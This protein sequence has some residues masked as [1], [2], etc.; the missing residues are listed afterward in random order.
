MRQ[1]EELRRARS[2]LKAALDRYAALYDFSPAGYLTLDT[3]GTI[4]EANLRA[5]TLLGVNQKELIGQSFG[6]F[7]AQDDQDTLQRHCQEV[8]KTGTPQS[9]EVRLTEKPGASCCV[10]LE[11]IVMYEE[12]GHRAY[13]RTALLDITER[14]RAEQEQARLIEDLTRS[15]QHFQSL[16]HWIPSAVG[17]S[18]VADG[19]FI[20]VNEGFSGLTGYRREEVIGRT[21]LEL[22]MWADPS[23]R[24]IVIQ[25]ILEQGFLHNREGQLRTKSGEIRSLMI[26]VHSIQLEGTP[27]LIY[28]AHDITERKLAEEALKVSERQFASFMDNLPGFAW[29]KDAQGR[30]LYA[31]RLFQESLVKHGD[32]KEKTAF[33]L[34]PRE[35][36]AKYEIDD[37][38]VLTSGAP[39]Q[40][41]E[42]Y[43]QDGEVRHALVS[44]FPIE[45][46]K[47]VSG[48][49]G[50]IAIDITERM[51]VEEALRKSE[52]RY[53]ALYQ[54]SPFMYFTVSADGAILSVN[55][56]GAESL[57][58]LVEELI[59]RPVLSIFHEEDRAAARVSLDRSLAN[60]T[61]LATWEFRK[62]RKGGTI[63]WVRETVRLIEDDCGALV[64]LLACEDITERKRAEEALRESE[65]RFRIMA[66]T[67]PTL[68]W[69]SGLDKL[70]IYFN[71]VWLDYTGRTMEQE[72][73]KGWVDSVHPG[74]FDRCWKTYAEAFDRRE[75]FQMEYRL[76]KAD[77]HYG[78][79]FDK[80]VP[81]YFPSG[82][83]AGYIG[84]CIDITE[85][86]WAE[87]A[88]QASDAFTRA[89]LNSLSAYVC[90]LDKEGIIV[91]TN[92]AW[93][94]FARQDV[95]SAFI[96]GE[97]SDHYLDHCRH[98]ITG[99]TVTDQAVLNGV[100][101]VLAGRELGFSYEYACQLPTEERWFLVRVTPL[102]DAR[103]V[104]ISHTDISR[105]VRMGLALEQHAVLLGEK[106][107]ELESLAGKL[108]EAQE[109]ERKRIAR[110]LHDDFN[111][112]LA[113]LSLELEG[114]ERAPLAP[115]ELM[116]QQLAAIRI[117][118]GKL[119]DDLHDLAYRLHPS[120]L[121]HVGLEVAVRDHVAEFAKR[122]GLPVR[123]IVREVPKTLSSEVATNLFRVLQESL[124]N[125]SKH[126]QATDVTVRLSGSSKGIGLSVR[127]NGKGFDLEDKNASVKGLG[128]VSM[129]ERARGLGGF[130]RIHS[131]PKN[132]TKVC[133]W[134]PHVQEDA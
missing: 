95:E 16:F 126:A 117:Q 123:F 83:F 97:V 75:P 51:Q 64:M 53:R 6:H 132:G 26:S 131:L 70:C 18:T 3:S 96:S 10:H 122:T 23:Q 74:D 124:Q 52:D 71:Q 2:E 68:I 87:T 5:G 103:G 48:L 93:K 114:M 20:D 102:K 15:Q 28:L 89:V 121:E 32:W 24:A 118:A 73:G 31:N 107:K 81:R 112:R 108:I 128:V 45:D 101:D 21:T 56:L 133:V 29:I 65:S 77:G 72:L 46:Y 106:Q 54:D 62:V 99:D 14:K 37:Q 90:V 4:M 104:V 27:C 36:A 1:P 111:Q 92:D 61:D 35:I 34:W 88:L 57:G 98:T 7:V 129:Q 79:V 69:M 59:G 49:M 41:I 130:L 105:R 66:D 60:P 25:E 86:K 42:P 43:V 100:E 94:E 39:L 125:V 9:C 12:P 109:G 8:F 134:I 127:D 40:A 67:A 85:R 50:G 110:E 113:A 82:E 78:W 19:R 76:R 33:E 119:S 30:H 116:V 115:S 11:S 22:G 63:L 38:K 55:R 44:K 120:L 91:A 58:F 47:G 13:W 84:T 80:G 17:I